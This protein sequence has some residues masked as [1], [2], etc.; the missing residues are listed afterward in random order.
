MDLEARYEKSGRGMP[1]PVFDPVL[2]DL[3]SVVSGEI[4]VVFPVN[5]ENEIKRAINLAKQ[6][7]LSYVLAGVVEG[8]RV[9]DL[10]KE[11]NVGLA[12]SLN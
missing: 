5:S 11:E 8:Y 2:R 1:R 9:I 4:T 6:F 10:I 12:V 7:N 3:Y